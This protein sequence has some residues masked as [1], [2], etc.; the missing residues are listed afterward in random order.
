M[1]TLRNFDKGRSKEDKGTVAQNSDK[2]FSSGSKVKYQCP[3][4]CHGEE[5]YDEPGL[6]PDSKM[7]MIPVGGGHIFY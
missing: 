1:E 7:Q 6:C 3:M 4:K 5:V 2:K